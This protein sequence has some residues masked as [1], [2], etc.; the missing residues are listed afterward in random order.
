M[1]QRDM[2]PRP[3][4]RPRVNMPRE[5]RG[6]RFTSVEWGRLQQAA[7]VNFTTPSDFVR[8]ACLLAVDDTVESD[9]LTEPLDTRIRR[10]G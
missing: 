4:G 10:A 1:R 6:I 7:R 9:D 8:S 2:S 3:V 5:V